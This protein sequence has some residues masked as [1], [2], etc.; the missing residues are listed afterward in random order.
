MALFIALP[1]AIQVFIIG[2]GGRIGHSGTITRRTL[3]FPRGRL[4]E[5]IN[6][7]DGRGE[8]KRERGGGGFR[9]NTGS[10]A[11]LQLRM[12]KRLKNDRLRNLTYAQGSPRI[13]LEMTSMHPPFRRW[14]L[15][16]YDEMA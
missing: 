1:S 14:D 16:S 10:G 4:I 2:G 6:A 7:K 3:R 15:K 5:R 8:R 11:I 12:A 9:R 13:T